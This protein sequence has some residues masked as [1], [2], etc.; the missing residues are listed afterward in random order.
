MFAVGLG[1][2]TS[3]DPIK[4]E[5]DFDVTNISASELLNGSEFSQYADEACTTPAEDGNYIKFNCP[6]VSALTI[7]Y[8]KADGSE[9]V[10]SSGKSGGVF[11]FVPK[12]GSD[13]NQTVYFRYVN[14]DGNE[15]VASKDFT[16]A[17][18]A[19]LKPEIKLLVSD[20]GQKT[21]KW[22]MDTNG[23]AW[24]NMAYVCEPG[25]SVAAGSQW[26]GCSPDL[27]W[28]K[29]EGGQY[30][31]TNGD[32]S[33]AG[34]GDVN[35]YMVLDEDG[36]IKTYDASG[37]L[38]R[39]ATYTVTGYD[40]TRHMKGNG[41]AAVAWDYGTLTTSEPAVMY[42]FMINGGGTTVT[43]FEILQLTPA[44][45][46]LVYA[47]EGT[48]TGSWKEATIW[49]F[50]STTDVTGCLTDNSEATW[51]WDD[52]SGAC[53]GNGGY[54]G[55]AYGGYSSVS[56]NS[57][58]GVTSDALAEQIS[59]Y[60]YGENDGAGTTMTFTNDGLIKK[61]S[62]GSGSFSYDASITDDIG[63][64]KEGKTMGRFNTTGSSILF[65][66]RI[67]AGTTV[68]EFD[69]VY[70]SDDKFVLSYPNYPAGGD[71]ASWMEGTFWRFKK[72]K[73]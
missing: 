40:G 48:E 34:E 67:N 71:N 35:A 32:D 5:K 36:F 28:S 68:D 63:G 59:N 46:A 55:L 29:D 45:L 6:N 70:I 43:S 56:G 33:K 62:G 49:R 8:I 7:Y 21:W 61:S 12:R 57:W 31:H 1:I 24:G 42:P 69:I 50:A 64:Y 11:Q 60:N 72:V 22:D 30:G 17:V 27:L 19:D 23:M 41:D 20:D 13:P 66:V 51:T 25:E 38:L 9:A 3:C 73:K 53:W 18:A 58:W 37:K 4:D 26:W 65:P 14:Q 47:P 10:L 16:L 44:K 54:T 52:E 15:A 2:L 39:S